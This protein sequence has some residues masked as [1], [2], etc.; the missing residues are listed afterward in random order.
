MNAYFAFLNRNA[1]NL[2]P[3]TEEQCFYFLRRLS[4]L[5]LQIALSMVRK[6]RPF[7]PGPGCTAESAWL[8]GWEVG[9]GG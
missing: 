8:M 3:L 9:R 7:G 2:M 1:S 6:E 4:S 5:T